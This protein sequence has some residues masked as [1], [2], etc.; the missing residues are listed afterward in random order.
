MKFSQRSVERWVF[1][2]TTY[3]NERA[4][5]AGSNKAGIKQ[6]QKVNRT[7]LDCPVLYSFSFLISCLITYRR[8]AI[9]LLRGSKGWLCRRLSFVWTGIETPSNSI[10]GF[11]STIGWKII[12][13]CR[14]AGKI[15]LGS[16]P[17]FPVAIVHPLQE[18]WLVRILG[19]KHVPFWQFK[20]TVAR[21]L[22]R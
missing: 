21:L 14:P 1:I 6:N 4:V 18:C 13:I 3:C 12:G 10:P 9:L 11:E 17:K 20:R 7:I 22:V 15:F 2:L 8:F 16:S 5:G 19:R